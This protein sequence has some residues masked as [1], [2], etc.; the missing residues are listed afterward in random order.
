MNTKKAMAVLATTCKNLMARVDTMESMMANLDKRVSKIE[1]PPPT[2][3]EMTRF[4]E[5]WQKEGGK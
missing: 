1:A 3:N 5:S 2:D 4:L